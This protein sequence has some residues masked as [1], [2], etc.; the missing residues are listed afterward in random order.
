MTARKH[1][2][3]SSRRTVHAPAQTF[4]HRTLRILGKT[5]KAFFADHVSRLGA[6]LAFYTTLAVAP[7]LVIAIALAGVL[8]E[9]SEARERII[10]EIELLAG[11]QASAAIEAIQNP[12]VSTT[13]TIATLIGAGTLIFGALGVFHHLQD[14]LNSIWRVPPVADKG[15]RAFLK[16]R[17][18]SLTAVMI[19]GFLLMVSL[20]ASATISWLGAQTISQFSLPVV[21]LQI[22]NQTLSFAMIALLF[23]LIF[24]LLPDVRVA[25]KHVW[26]GAVVTALLFTLG[27][28]VLGSYLGH[29]RVTSAYGAAGSLVALLLWCYY[30]G[31]IVFL[32]A[33]FTRITSLSNGGR[34]FS[35]LSS[36]AEQHRRA[37]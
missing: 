19:T 32:G 11:P 22:V 29:A 21:A 17:M 15:W 33:E 7:L 13:G 27:K 20:V 26:L 25:W 4:L 3:K 14:A 34:D 28:G 24:K 31:Q 37:S 30:A 2:T 6:A 12:I 16:A 1:N 5:G 18:F 35:A 36:P 9:Q 23:A 10:G 8:F